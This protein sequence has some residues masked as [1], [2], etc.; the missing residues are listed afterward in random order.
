[1]V[2]VCIDVLNYI[3][4][5][6]HSI[7]VIFFYCKFFDFKLFVR[8]FFSV[9]LSIYLPMQKF[10]PNLLKFLFP[11]NLHHAAAFI[12]KKKVRGFLTISGQFKKF[13]FQ[14][15]CALIFF[16]PPII[17]L[18]ARFCVNITNQNEPNKFRISNSSKVCWLLFFF[19]VEHHI[20]RK[21][22]FFYRI[23]RI[24]LQTNGNELFSSG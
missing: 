12:Y 23:T 9:T 3:G 24:K 7:F 22:N 4:F 2:P 16:L 6:N 18:L 5:S 14:T 21:F 8:F 19:S 17:S 10:T 13:R 15:I 1:M 11:N 20:F